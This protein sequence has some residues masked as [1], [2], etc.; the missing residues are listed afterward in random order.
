MDAIQLKTSCICGNARPYQDCCGLFAAVPDSSKGNEVSRKWAAFRHA[1]HELYMYSVPLRNLYEAYWEKLGQESYPHHL[2]MADSEYG[3]AVTA[4]F[5]WDYSVQFSDARPIL[6]AARDV[7][8][9]NVRMANDFREWSLSSFSLGIVVGVDARHGHLRML[10]SEKIHQ[11]V[12]GGDLPEPGTCVAVRLLSYRGEEYIHPAM[13][14]FPRESFS[15]AEADSGFHRIC[16]ALGMK[17][18]AGLR[19]DVQCDEWRRHGALFLSLWRE[20]VYDAIIGTPSRNAGMVAHP[21]NLPDSISVT[22]KQILSGGA[23]QTGKN[24]FEI[25]YRDVPLAQLNM[26]KSGIQGVLVD[27]AFRPHVFSWLAEHLDSP[28]SI[29]KSTH[30]NNA[31]PAADM[32]HWIRRPLSFLNEESPLQASSHDF[33]KRKL[34]DLIDGMLK[35]GSDVEMLRQRLGL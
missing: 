35:Q 25:R 24:N 14:V 4:N 26:R 18:I 21:F 15:E 6:R 1:L 2:L 30:E 8:V 27:E 32:E 34:R 17:S 10:G 23:F 7:E 16:K 20:Q 11:V 33:G 19:P 3:R 12:H 9:K 5:F 28:D 29:P 31:P 13:L 22:A